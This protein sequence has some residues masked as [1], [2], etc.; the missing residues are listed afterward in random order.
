MAL[1]LTC[2]KCGQRLS[3]PDELRGRRVRCPK[4]SESHLV[5]EKKKAATSPA[6]AKP[7]AM[8]RH[9]KKHDKQQRIDGAP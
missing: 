7:Q 2:T 8:A 1:V 9:A 3:I 5:G 4:C 6:A